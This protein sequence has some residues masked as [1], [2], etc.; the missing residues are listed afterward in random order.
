MNPNFLPVLILFLSQ[1]NNVINNL[2]PFFGFILYVAG[3]KQY[4][5]KSRE[6]Q[7]Q[8]KS[9]MSNFKCFITDYNE[10]LEPDGLIIHK[11]IF[12]KFIFYD[13]WDKGLILVCKKETYKFLTNVSYTK[14]EIQLDT[15][16]IPKKSNDESDDESQTTCETSDEEEDTKNISYISK[17][18]EYGYFSYK[19]RKINLAQMSHHKAP[20]MFN[21]QEELFKK[22][23]NFYKHNNFCKV[24]LSGQPG[25]GKT[26]FAYLLAQ[27]IGCYLCDCYN[28]Y[29][30]SSNFNEVYNLCKIGPQ[31]PIILVLDEVD[32]LLEKIHTPQKEEHKKFSREIFDKTSWNNFLDKIDFGLFPY[33]IVIM[34]SNRPKSYIDNMDPSYLRQ[35]RINIIDQW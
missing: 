30:P 2:K 13:S 33:L 5:I 17:H 15:N 3:Y 19:T 35:G 1:L 6:V 26:Y 4:K 34:N 20:I 7:N 18:G 9:R 10:N 28:P 12:P 24:Y 25:C 8:I 11:S 27:K 22:I 29:E 16:Y 21:R 23:M 32:I 31:K 14:K